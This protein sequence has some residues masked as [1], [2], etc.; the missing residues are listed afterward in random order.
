ME[1][2]ADAWRQLL[3]SLRRPLT[4]RQRKKDHKRL[5]ELCADGEAYDVGGPVQVELR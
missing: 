4:V 3:K 5:S 2:A 1:R